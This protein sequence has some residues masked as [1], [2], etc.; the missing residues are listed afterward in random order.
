MERRFRLT[1]STDFQRVRRGGK[2]YAHPLLVLVVAPNT[3]DGVRVGVA[4]SQTVGKAVQRNKAKRRIRA[5]VRQLLP[6]IKPGWD[7]VFLARKPIV[8][9]SF[10]ELCAAIRALLVRSALLDEQNGC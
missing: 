8:Q 10:Q 4:A 5:G 9:A 3:L 7:L 6:S 2:S 1:R